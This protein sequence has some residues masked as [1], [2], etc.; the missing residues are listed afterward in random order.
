MNDQ[1][2]QGKVLA[3]VQCLRVEPL[4]HGLVVVQVLTRE[5][6]FQDRGF[7]E[8]LKPALHLEVLDFHQPFHSVLTGKGGKLG[9]SVQGEDVGHQAGFKERCFGIVHRSGSTQLHLPQKEIGLANFYFIGI[10][11]GPE[12]HLQGH[13]CG[14]VQQIFILAKPF[15]EVHNQDGRHILLGFGPFPLGRDGSCEAKGNLFRIFSLPSPL[16]LLG[17]FS[18]L[19][20]RLHFRAVFLNR[21]LLCRNFRSASGRSIPARWGWVCLLLQFLTLTRGGSVFFLFRLL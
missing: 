16:F 18:F 12:P 8:G 20:D 9:E 5:T 14:L 13:L 17:S 15:C 1:G 19:C 6:D 11:P 10:D 2:I 3:F 7:L 21:L 4:D